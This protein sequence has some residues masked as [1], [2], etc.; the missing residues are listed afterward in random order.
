MCGV[1]FDP[2][3]LPATMSTTRILC[4]PCYEKRQ[5]EKAAS[6]AK[7][8]ASASSV[9]PPAPAPK[10]VAA[11]AAPRAPAP[12]PV[13]K[14]AVAPAAQSAAAAPPRP[15][16]P[17]PAPSRVSDAARAPVPTPASSNNHHA[18]PAV[19]SGSKVGSGSR[20]GSGSKVG[21]ASKVSSGSASRHGPKK[22]A[23]PE[24]PVDLKT[25]LRAES[26]KMMD[27]QTKLGLIIG[28]VFLV[29]A[30][31]Y[32]MFVKNTTQEEKFKSEA[33]TKM[34]ADLLAGFKKYDVDTVDG[35]KALQIAS[36]TSKEK[37]TGTTISAD[38]NTLRI[39]AGI[40]LQNDQ[41]KRQFND[42][43]TALEAQARDISTKTA[44][45]LRIMRKSADTLALEAQAFGADAVTRITMLRGSLQTNIGTKL[46]EEAI[47]F[48]DTQGGTDPMG[49]LNKLGQTED[50]LRE[51]YDQADKEKN[52]QAKTLFTSY[53]QD[54][55][56]RT[57][58]LATVTF[59]EAAVENKPW[60]GLLDGAIANEWKF[61][62]LSGAVGKVEA[63]RL[64]LVGGDAESKGRTVNSVGDS[65]QWRDF[66]IEGE[67]TVEAGKFVLVFR[68]GKNPDPRTCDTVEI[69]ADE[70][71][72][73]AGG[74][75]S[76][77][78]QLIGST[79]KM[80]WKD[81]VFE[82]VDRELD[83]R[84]N[85]HGAFG[86]V[87]NTGAKVTFTRLRVK[88]LR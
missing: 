66:V 69:A 30:L 67:F 42:R 37:W 15:A 44:E 11:A 1:T 74:T 40:T 75:Y 22:K 17:P 23:E 19:G 45:E 87:L 51:L 29:G 73:Q 60:L 27:K 26:T 35:A 32:V 52:A 86:V 49:A 62:K 14:T 3:S 54:L 50:D 84:T 33:Y 41:D 78:Y 68:L 47:T 76:F 25:A 83:F 64:V 10:P 77:R 56:A 59:N 13:A 24:A 4:L 43:L 72:I 53:L 81:D 82:A 9:V 63:G 8:A 18:A 20:V 28:V 34:L 61:T 48:A 36:D 39:K 71:R 2:Q 57:D 12:A 80:T 58:K 70:G 7:A 31:G 38:V 16:P 5:A 88:E 65:R 6:K 21:S 79:A 46:K 85:R 55:Y